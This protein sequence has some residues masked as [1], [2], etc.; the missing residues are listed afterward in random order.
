MI[1]ILIFFSVC[2]AAK[3]GY[4]EAI[5]L[6]SKSLESAVSDNPHI[7]ISFYVP[8]CMNCKRLLPELSKAAD[9]LQK[10]ETDV[11]LAKIN[12]DVHK[13]SAQHYK[14]ESFPTILYFMHGKLVEKYP[15]KRTAEA[16]VE[17]LLEKI[18]SEAKTD[19]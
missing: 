9:I 12:V 15:G 18:S 3:S 7:L 10:N 13:N 2:A 6:D 17:Y 14:I 4:K 8:W 11:A 19:L 1:S 5:E 16:I